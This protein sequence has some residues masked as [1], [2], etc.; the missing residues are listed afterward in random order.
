MWMVTS[1]VARLTLQIDQPVVGMVAI[2]SGTFLMGSPTNE[3]FHTPAEGPQTRV[4]LSQGFWMSK[5]ET[6]QEEYQAVMGK[7]PSKFM[8]DLTRPVEQVVW[9]EATNYCGKLTERERVAGRLPVGYVYR[10]PTEAE[11]E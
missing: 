11:W 4:T 9:A 2:P 10:L 6:T 5:Y 1:E 3:E 8:G 7:N